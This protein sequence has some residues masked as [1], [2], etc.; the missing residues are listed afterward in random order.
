MTPGKQAVMRG[1]LRRLIEV[2]VQGC[3]IGTKLNTHK[4]ARRFSNRRRF[5][6]PHSISKFLYERM[7]LERTGW[8][9]WVVIRDSKVPS[10]E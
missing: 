3:T 2:Y 5:V 1:N 6:T 7:D 4:L 8:N 10:P 9:E